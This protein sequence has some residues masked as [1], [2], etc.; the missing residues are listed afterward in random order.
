MIRPILRLA[1]IALCAAALSGCISLLP[2][3]KPAQLYRFGA[4]AAAAAA[5][6]RPT[7]AV[8]VFLTNGSFQE[9]SSDD[10][11]LTV[12][13]GQ[14]AW[15]GSWSRPTF[16]FRSGSLRCR[17]GIRRKRRAPARSRWTWP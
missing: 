6:A 5:P 14:A 7:S 9:E 17:S 15:Q 3:T 12:T 2:K 8:A 13:G 10:R 16:R 1:T 4:P 11:M